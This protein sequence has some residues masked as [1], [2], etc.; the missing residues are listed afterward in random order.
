KRAQTQPGTPGSCSESLEFSLR[1]IHA[2]KTP[3]P[4][5]SASPPS[6]WKVVYFLYLTKGSDRKSSRDTVYEAV[7]Q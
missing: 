1:L 3:P 7:S 5:Q 2:P 4:V 6:K